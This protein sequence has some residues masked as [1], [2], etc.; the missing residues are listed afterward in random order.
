MHYE[1]KVLISKINVHGSAGDGLI[2]TCPDA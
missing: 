2:S 1:V